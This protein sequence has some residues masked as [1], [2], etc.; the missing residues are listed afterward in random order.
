LRALIACER[1]LLGAI[2]VLLV[3]LF[4][5]VAQNAQPVH[6]PITSYG[7][8]SSWNFGWGRPCVHLVLVGMGLFLEYH[9][10]VRWACLMG[11]GQAIALDTL[12]SY[13]V[14]EEI[15]CV[16]MGR[17]GLPAGYSWDS[18]WLT[19]VRDLTSLLLEVWAL[20]LMAYLNT[21]IGPWNV[22]YSYRQLR[23]DSD[24]RNNEM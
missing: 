2:L 5:A 23:G 15:N 12:S 19:G 22:R 11:L 18:L 10:A 17:C 3:P 13:D 6:T 4:V 8:G 9:P 7:N 14:Q 21:A 20:L 16:G 24:K 1:P